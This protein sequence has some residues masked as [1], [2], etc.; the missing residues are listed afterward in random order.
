LMFNLICLLSVTKKE[1]R[2]TIHSLDI[3]PVADAHQKVTLGHR[4]V[5]RS[6]LMSSV[7][8]PNNLPL[9]QAYSAC[10]CGPVVSHRTIS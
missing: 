9:I 2:S 5:K 7:Y 10:V 3:S 1:E 6:N 4:I 8:L